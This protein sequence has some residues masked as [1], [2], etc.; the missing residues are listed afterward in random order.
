LSAAQPSKPSGVVNIAD[1]EPDKPVA[2]YREKYT[3]APDATVIHYIKRIFDVCYSVRGGAV[4]GFTRLGVQRTPTSHH[5]H[6]LAAFAPT[7]ERERKKRLQE[8]RR[9]TYQERKMRKENRKKK[10]K[11]RKKER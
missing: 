3:M 11:W 1:G 6:H 5:H 4:V 8:E 10:G 9:R 7:R 2:L